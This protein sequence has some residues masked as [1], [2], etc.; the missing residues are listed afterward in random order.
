MARIC[1]C[2]ARG[3]IMPTRSKRYE[4]SAETPKTSRLRDRKR[5]ETL[6]KIAEN[7]I[8]IFISKGYDLTSI[9]E[10]AIA[11]G[12]SRR[13]FFNYFM[14]KDD[15]IHH[16]ALSYYKEI[17]ES[18]HQQQC[19]GSP[20]DIACDALIKLSQKFNSDRSFAITKLLNDNKSLIERQGKS[21]NIVSSAIMA[22]FKARWPNHEQEDSLALA[23][24]IVAAALRFAVSLWIDGDKKKDLTECLKYTFNILKNHTFDLVE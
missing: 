1:M 7:G 14:S 16:H 6:Q 5:E 13:T 3:L 12:I 4:V 24:I 2:R 9:D 21:D 8:N 11:S 17:S 23:S 19:V 22:G 18:I 10:I 15:I 20:I